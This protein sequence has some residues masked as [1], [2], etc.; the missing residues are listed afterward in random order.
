MVIEID[1]DVTFDQL[2][3]Y[4]N[5]LNRASDVDASVDLLLPIKLE[6]NFT[7]PIKQV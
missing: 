6:N 5:R 4:Y 2:E 7:L 3:T 1:K